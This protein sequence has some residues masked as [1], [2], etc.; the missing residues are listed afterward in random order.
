[1]ISIY[2]QLRRYF[3]VVTVISVL[4]IFILSNLGMT[5]FFKNYIEESNLKSDQKIVQ[6]IED[7]LG[8]ENRVSMSGFSGLMQF[9]RGEGAEIILSDASGSLILDSRSMGNMHRGMGRGPGMMQS[10]G[11]ESREADLTY[12][13]YPVK[14]DGKSIGKVEIGVKQTILAAAETGPSS[15]MNAVYIIALGLSILLVLLMSKYVTGKFLQPL[16]A[17]KNNIQ[18]IATQGR[19]QLAPISSNTTEI[20]ELAQATEELS[21]NIEEQEKLRKR[22]ISD[23]AHELRTPLATL[24][25]LWRP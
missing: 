4:V 13:E 9:I 6:N 2:Q 8:T 15:T 11:T 21:R 17:V 5:V 14:V 10:N 25:S 16:L 7:L 23:V 1:M 19:Q 22:L 3:I 12:R 24:Q 18:S 20:R